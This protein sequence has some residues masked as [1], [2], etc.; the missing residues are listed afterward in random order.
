MCSLSKLN[1]KLAAIL[2]CVSIEGLHDKIFTT[3]LDHQAMQIYFLVFLYSLLIIVIGSNKIISFER[4]LDK[5]HH[6]KAT[7]HFKNNKSYNYLNKKIK[8]KFDY[9]H[10]HSSTI[11]S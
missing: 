7:I 5:T 1:Y 11:I 9:L 4:N 10:P 6:V 8:S 2:L 3:F